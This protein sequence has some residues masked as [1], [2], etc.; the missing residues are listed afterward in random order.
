MNVPPYFQVRTLPNFTIA[1]AE[2]KNEQSM[3]IYFSHEHCV[4][5]MFKRLRR[6]MSS[7]SC[8]NSIFKQ[9][10]NVTE[11]E[12]KSPELMPVQSS[13]GLKDFLSQHNMLPDRDFDQ[14]FAFDLTFDDYEDIT[15]IPD[16][17]FDA[18]SDEELQ[19]IYDTTLDAE[20]RQILSP[21]IPRTH[22]WTLKKGD[23]VAGGHG[24]VRQGKLYVVS[25]RKPNSNKRNFR[26]DKRYIAAKK[27]LK[28][29]SFMDIEIF[30]NEISIL[31]SCSHPNVLKFLGVVFLRPMKIY[32]ITEFCDG[33]DLWHLLYNS[34]K[35]RTT[36]MCDL[37]HIG[38]DMAKGMEHL[39]KKNIL[40]R[41]FKS[42]NVLLFNNRAEWNSEEGPYR[43]KW[44]AKIADFGTA[45]STS[46][47]YSK[48]NRN[49][50]YWTTIAG[51]FQY[52][53][54]EAQSDLEMPINYKYSSD[55]YSLG[56]V[57][58]ELVFGNH[59]FI[60]L[61][62]K[63]VFSLLAPIFQ[64]IKSK[65]IKY[66]YWVRLNLIQE[67]FKQIKHGSIP[68][69]SPEK[70][71]ILPSMSILLFNFYNFG[72][73]PLFLG[74]SFSDAVFNFFDLPRLFSLATS[75]PVSTSI[76]SSTRPHLYSLFSVYRICCD[77]N[78]LVP[79]PA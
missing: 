47:G 41:D 77:T 9:E 30:L 67:W 66:F 45:L 56:I 58:V 20:A 17:E 79:Q 11:P 42:S 37:V 29:T 6:F 5:T 18:G 63:E 59:P 39:R 64:S 52:S 2:Y 54:P 73:L 27:I 33:H 53:A 31:K 57:F 19:F 36:C 24:L 3:K 7:L 75:T 65:A 16:P 60:Q 4:V 61:N 38:I 76:T 12:P 74:F 34:R 10:K 46:C 35:W 23:Q 40:H 43:P 13:N 72:G 62:E 15:F 25:V 55:L 32:L 69:D 21:Q 78:G 26:I 48:L 14:A 68:S 70:L 44:V 49:M 51:N 71:L 50:D 1:G 8:V 22:I 28:P